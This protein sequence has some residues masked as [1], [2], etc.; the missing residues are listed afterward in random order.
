M[1]AGMFYDVRV[2][3]QMDIQ[4]CLGVLINGDE[5][6][7]GFHER[8]VLL[9]KRQLFCSFFCLLLG[10]L[11]IM[12]QQLSLFK[13]LSF[14]VLKRDGSVP[15]ARCPMSGFGPE[16]VHSGPLHG[17]QCLTYIYCEGHHGEEKMPNERKKLRLKNQEGDGK[18][19]MKIRGRFRE[20]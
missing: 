15:P 10:G 16:P 17:K 5:A 3:L 9:E 4:L 7:S 1:T 13:Q 6:F 20:R 19:R 14:L 11:I 2:N 12:Q 8:T 18:R